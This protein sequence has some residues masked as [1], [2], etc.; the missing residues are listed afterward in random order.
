MLNYPYLR[1]GIFRFSELVDPDADRIIFWDDSADTAK[2]LSIGTSLS[3]SGTTLNAIQG[4]RTADSPS[5]AWLTLTGNLVLDTK[6]IS[7]DTS[8]GTK[9]GTSTSQKIGFFNK[10]PVAQQSA[11]TSALTD[12]THTSP[13]ADY[14]IQ[15]LVQSTS[16]TA[17]EGFGFVT[18]D[19][20]NTVLKVIQANKVRINE[21]ETKLQALGLLA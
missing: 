6:N 9:I 13:S 20:G 17:G 5:F 12:L 21:I 14:A 3:L 11:L 8:T 10:T 2:F 1:L 19:E 7:T 16:P 15:D 18:K 4:I